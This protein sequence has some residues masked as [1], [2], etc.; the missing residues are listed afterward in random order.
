MPRVGE[1]YHPMGGKMGMGG[2]GFKAALTS[3]LFWASSHQWCILRDM[4]TSKLDA[5]TLKI[6]HSA[7]NNYSNKPAH[8]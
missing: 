2:D 7:P 5:G 1:D 8:L 6:Y 4:S 3:E